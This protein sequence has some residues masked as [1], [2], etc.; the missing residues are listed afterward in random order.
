MPS[1][2]I[3]KTGWNEMSARVRYEVSQDVALNCSTVTVTG[4]ELNSNSNYGNFFITGSVTLDGKS[5][6]ELVLGNTVGYTVTLAKG[7]WKPVGSVTGGGIGASAVRISHGNDGTK[8][9]SVSVSLKAYSKGGSGG[10]LASCSGAVNLTL[11]RIPRVSGL[12]A[13]G[14]TLGQA[15]DIRITRAAAFL[16]TVSWQCGGESGVI[17]EKTGETALTWTPPVGLA[18]QNTQGGAVA[19]TLTVTTYAGETAIGSGSIT[20]SCPIPESIVPTLTVSVTDNTGCFAKYGCYVRSRSQARVKT[21]A[22]GAYGSTVRSIAAVCGNLTFSGADGVFSLPDAGT[23]TVRV[24]VTDSRGRTASAS[25]SVT[26]ADYQNPSVT[27]SALYR[28]DSSGGPDPQGSYAKAVFTGAVTSLGGKNSAVY[29]LKKRVRGTD[30]WTASEISGYTGQF[31]PQGEYVFPAGVDSDFEV[32]LT[33]GDDFTEVP[34]PVAVLPVAFS[35]LD[36]HRD[37]RSAGI[38]QRAST[39]GAV[40]LGGDTVHHGHRI[41]DVAQPRDPDDAVTLRALLDRTYPVGAVYISVSD[42]SPTLLFGGVWERI[43]DRFLL[44]SG[45]AYAA[46]TYGG[47]ASVPLNTDQLPNHTHTVSPPGVN[48]GAEV[49]DQFGNYPVRIDRDKRAN[50]SV[51]GFNTGGTGGNQ[52]HNNMPPYLAV[53]MWKRTA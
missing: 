29:R 44:A 35:L 5:A 30:A 8:T 39:P 11:P 45:S 48:D 50:W 36:F 28:C 32:I 6:C 21:A 13:A 22:A 41:R 33:A 24:T 14:V 1:V 10:A 17:A 42:T 27:V 4:L 38:L 18:A 23:V 15:M 43:L 31:T 9:I 46:G 3:L 40:D 34:G 52:P 19:V 16:D 25:A 53:Y 20:V 37:S 47:E 7:E 26:V 49:T 2:E 12:S 51:T